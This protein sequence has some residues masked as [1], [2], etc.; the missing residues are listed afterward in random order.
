MYVFV[1]KLEKLSLNYLRYSFLSGAL[2]IQESETTNRSAQDPG[3]ALLS[4]CKLLLT[5]IIFAQ[6]KIQ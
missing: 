6:S 2:K 1:E 3:M 5:Y 4:F